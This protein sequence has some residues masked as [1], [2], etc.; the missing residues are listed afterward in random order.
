MQARAKRRRYITAIFGCLALIAAIF[1][2]RRWQ[3]VALL[4]AIFRDDTETIARLAFLLTNMNQTDEAKKPFLLIALRENRFAAAKAMLAAGADPNTMDT[5]TGFTGL[6]WATQKADPDLVLA[7]LERGADLNAMTK[8]NVNALMMAAGRG[9]FELVKLLLERGAP[10][11]AQGAFGETA[12]SYAAWNRHHETMRLLLE[13]GANP[14][15]PTDQQ[16]LERKSRL[17]AREVLLPQD[18][19]PL[20][21]AATQGDRIGVEILLKHGADIEIRG[22]DGQ[23]ALIRAAGYRGPE[24]MGSI[25][26]EEVRNPILRNNFMSSGGTSRPGLFVLSRTIRFNRPAPCAEELIRLLLERGANPKATDRLGRTAL[27]YVASDTK[28]T[29][30]LLERGADAAARSQARVFITSTDSM[31]SPSTALE[32]AAQA[33]NIETMQMVLA[34][35]MKPT[36]SEKDSALRLAVQHGHAPAMRFL[37]GL[38]AVLPNRDKEALLLEVT[39]AGY[40]PSMRLLLGQGMKF[41]PGTMKQLLLDVASAGHVEAMQVL[42][43]QGVRLKDY[44]ATG[45]TTPLYAAVLSRKPDMVRLL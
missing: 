13:H 20:I 14:N 34:R 5:L 26:P 45:E 9:R 30:L 3:R 24:F 15:L 37:L 6:L 21:I 36:Q 43:D 28:L 22:Y 42:L 19:R 2:F 25:A 29:R 27:M 17:S 7:F 41:P 10:V 35:G 39:R 1:V 33:G 16:E 38:G 23:T 4:E 12:L 44:E 40:A 11:N 32:W 8:G 31:Y 18:T